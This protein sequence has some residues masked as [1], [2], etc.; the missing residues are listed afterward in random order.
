LGKFGGEVFFSENVDSGFESGTRNV[1]FRELGV[2]LGLR[3]SL[4]AWWIR[5]V[6]AVDSKK[7]K[8]RGGKKKWE[9]RG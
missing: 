4:I 2:C 9:F 3:L 6:G 8:K 5:V 7:K 1:F